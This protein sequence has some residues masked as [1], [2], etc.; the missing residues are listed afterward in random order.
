MKSLARDY[1]KALNTWQLQLAFVV[2]L[3]FV[4]TFQY[5]SEYLQLEY[6]T[7]WD[8]SSHFAAIKYYSDNIFPELFGWMD[9]WN[10]GQPWPLG[11]PPL[12][13][14]IYG[15][16]FQLF[17]GSELAIFKLSFVFLT[18]LLP[19]LVFTFSKKLHKKNYAGFLS[20][21]LS[22]FFLVATNNRYLESGGV[23][24]RGTFQVGLY[25]QLLAT[26]LLLTW[27]LIHY[28]GR[29]STV[30][31]VLSL[32]LFSSI[33]LTNIHTALVAGIIWLFHSMQHVSQQRSTKTL[34]LT[35]V[36]PALVFGLCTFWIFTILNHPGNTLT[37]TDIPVETSRLLINNWLYIALGILTS[38]LIVKLK[39]LNQLPLVLS[40]LTVFIIAT[41]PIRDFLP[42][43][44]L[45]ANRIVPGLLLILIILIGGLPNLIT[46]LKIRLRYK[47]P[48][49]AVLAIF[50][51]AWNF[52]FSDPAI[53]SVGGI[54]NLTDSEQELAEYLRNTEG[55]SL[56]QSWYREDGKGYPINPLH[57][58]LAGLSI[59]EKHQGFWGIFRESAINMP[60]IQPIRNA[61]AE[62]RRESYAVDCFL[63]SNPIYNPNP[64]I[65][66]D[67]YKQDI[68]QQLERAKLYGVTHLAVTENAVKDKLNALDDKYISWDK[69]FGIWSVYKI[70]NLEIPNRHPVLISTKLTTSGRSVNTYDWIR[71]N[72]EWLYRLPDE[73]MFVKS[74]TSEIANSEEIYLFDDYF[75]VDYNYSDLETTRDQLLNFSLS[76]NLYLHE[77]N[78][79]ILLEIAKLKTSDHHIFIIPKTGNVRSD[80]NY[81]INLATDNLDDSP[82]NGS[83]L[84]TSF[85]TTDQPTN[86]FL[87]SPSL[88]YVID[89]N[90]YSENEQNISVNPIGLLISTLSISILASILFA[91]AVKHYMPHR[92]TAIKT[93]A[94]QI[95]A[96]SIKHLY[97]VAFT[98]KTIIWGYRYQIG[99]YIITLAI[100]V[101]YLQDYLYGQYVGGFDGEFHYTSTVAFSDN[102]GT[103]GFF[104]WIDSWN[105]GTAWPSGYTPLLSVITASLY[106]LLPGV[107]TVLIFKSIF[108]TLILTF[109]L[110]VFNSIKFLNRASLPRF[111]TAIL[112]L[113]FFTHDRHFL[114]S[115]ITIGGILELG[116]YPFFLATYLFV[117]ALPF[118]FAKVSYK[119]S[120][121]LGI[122]STLV[123][124]S[125]FHVSLV[126]ILFVLFYIQKIIKLRVWKPLVAY[127]IPVVTLSG[128]WLLG[129]ATTSS[130]SLS[131]TIRSL[132]VGEFARSLNLIILLTMIIGVYYLFTATKAKK[133]ESRDIILIIAVF[134]II[135]ALLP[136]ELINNGL[137]WQPNRL[138]SLGYILLV[139]FYAKTLTSIKQ[140]YRPALILATIMLLPVATI[141]RPQIEAS[142][143]TMSTEERRVFEY[144]KNDDSTYLVENWLRETFDSATTDSY[145]R[146]LRDR[147]KKNS[148]FSNIIAASAPLNKYKSVWGVFRESS[149]SSVYTQPIRNQFSEGPESYGTVCYLCLELGASSPVS[150]PTEFLRSDT[151][152]M[153]NRARWIGVEKLLIR[154]DLVK[155]NLMKSESAILEEVIGKWHVYY[156]PPKQDIAYTPILTFAEVGNRGRLVSGYD[157]MRLNEEWLYHLPAEYPLVRA[158]SQILDDTTDLYDFN[159]SLIADYNYK[160]YKLVSRRLAN[161]AEDN[162]L[163]IIEENNLLYNELLDLK[164]SEN[165]KNILPIR[166]TGQIRNELEELIGDLEYRIKEQKLIKPNNPGVSY[167]I[168]PQ[169]YHPWWYDR[170][171]GKVYMVSPTITMI[172]T[173]NSDYELEYLPFNY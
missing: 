167:F 101:P 158:N 37:Q 34:A 33:V 58:P 21:V 44:P 108:T 20:G 126:M 14:Y 64:D 83:Y 141:N 80:I 38:L 142:N 162:L 16:L 146:D 17:P 53:N 152:L 70:N 78:D 67:F 71:I 111:A 32:V 6:V 77:T 40:A 63:C 123:L 75:I 18:F 156:I 149:L 49:L 62:T 97:Q 173:P 164:E 9:S 138:I 2:I 41:F 74:N 168:E 55:K 50:L 15:F 99:I 11:Y 96:V 43:I 104:G 52:T 107:S 59:S 169:T 145:D 68:K 35:V 125:N 113:S 91:V 66:Q 159:I 60:F 86:T 102:L 165:I 131:A 36:Y 89:I 116:N 3:T 48:L 136:F 155:D 112:A 163:Y 134:V 82:Y 23:D 118:C 79:P 127:A 13:I 93:Y 45:Q 24:M 90:S 39:K 110:L 61:F 132:S 106:K 124:L 109:P 144:I 26:V 27:M 30:K 105:L 28:F 42:A 47:L 51:L 94:T 69:N 120:I 92:Y 115:D 4:L 139:I 7:G 100:L 157:W 87:A 172:V 84:A 129:L 54:D 29:W 151:T 73:V 95:Y 170:L 5:F 147:Q 1:I 76:H 56:I 119:N 137:P 121:R 85:V 88:T 19:I 46:Q 122:A 81:L 133:L 161:Y 8:G 22:V 171:G 72:E 65:Y 25:P 154:S 10:S 153:L 31:N 12:F 57:S 150:I 114:T 128:Y 143:F 103:Y 135:S 148:K 117:L 98:I 130:S 166:R 160:D 140:R